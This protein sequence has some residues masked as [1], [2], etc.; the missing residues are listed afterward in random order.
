M[1]L[2]YLLARSGIE[3]LFLEKHADF[4]RDSRGDTLHPSRLEG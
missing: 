2:G 3:V 4:L 1:M